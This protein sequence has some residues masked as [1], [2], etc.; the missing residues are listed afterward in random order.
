[1]NQ[2]AVNHEGKDSN[3][4]IGYHNFDLMANS[5]L[6]LVHQRR[7]QRLY[8]TQLLKL[9]TATTFSLFE[10]TSPYGSYKESCKALGERHV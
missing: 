7:L 10:P 9:T 2:K 4:P 5:D 8:S 6:L 3:K 1:M